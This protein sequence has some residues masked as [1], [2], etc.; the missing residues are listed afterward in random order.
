MI[1]NKK[2][3]IIHMIYILFV[4]VSISLK[5]S[6]QSFA[7]DLV[8]SHALDQ[9]SLF[10]FIIKRYHTWSGRVFL[11]AIMVSTINYHW[12]WKLGIPLSLLLLCLSASRIAFGRITFSATANALALFLF[13]PK[14]I[15]ENA[16][17]WVTGFYNYLLPAS[18]AIYAM[19]VVLNHT[20]AGKKEKTLAILSSFIFCYNEQTA[21][22]IIL[23]T[24][25]L[26]ISSSKYRE[27]YIFLFTL[28]STINA[29]ILFLSPGNYVRTVKES[30]RWLPGF[31]DIGLL[32]KLNFGFDRIHQTVVIHDS[33]LFGIL[34]L[35]SILL[36][37]NTKPFTKISTLFLSCLFV[38]LSIMAIKHLHLFDLGLSFYNEDNLNPNRWISYSRYLSYFTT[39]MV[40]ISIIYAVLISS[41]KNKE[42]LSP[43]VA[44]LLGYASIAM[45]S[46][47]P[48]VFASWMRVLFIFEV[49]LIIVCMK[50][51]AT[52]FYKDEKTYKHISFALLASS[53]LVI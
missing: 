40:I 30:W 51:F 23:S 46:F 33:M 36:I 27:R 49:I 39:L 26:I 29:L 34:C 47:S 37:Y 17:W 19:S 9:T 24:G 50:I 41:L 43:F 18:I 16:A 25:I 35:L 6:L 10:D 52:S 14:S 5:I 31:Q 32:K 11:D 22:L 2:T 20:K 48:T 53:L 1:A 15:N 38:H 7:D 28:I 4:L 8:F 42:N 13:I 21:F 45:L 12:V 3:N 44:L